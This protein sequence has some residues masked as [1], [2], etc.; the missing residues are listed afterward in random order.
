MNTNGNQNCA[1]KKQGFIL[2]TPRT[3][4]PD[5]LSEPHRRALEGSGTQPEPLSWTEYHADGTPYTVTH[6]SNPE[7]PA[8]E[9]HAIRNALE[10]LGFDK[11]SEPDRIRISL[12]G[13]TIG[14][15]LKRGQA[16]AGPYAPDEWTP[17]DQLHDWFKE[18]QWELKWALAD[19][20]NW[21]ALFLRRLPPPFT[22]P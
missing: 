6:Y 21:Q 14:R 8:H 15:L 12:D 22:K 4:P 19:F 17:D 16:H 1:R 7:L 18:A 13:Q 20:R 11:W 9:N 10:R 2:L 5:D 3:V